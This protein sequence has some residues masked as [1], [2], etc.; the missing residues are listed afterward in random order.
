MNSIAL[1]QAAL[2]LPKQERAQLAHLLLDSLDEPTEADTEKRWALEAS[3]RADEIDQG[4]V[5]LVAGEAF[6]GQVQA[7]FR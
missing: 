7:L 2:D 5:Q 4:T 1:Q 3:R 6:E